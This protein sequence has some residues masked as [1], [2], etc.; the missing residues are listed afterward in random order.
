MFDVKQFSSDKILSH[1]DRINE[2][3]Q[4]GLSRPITYELDMTNVCNNNCP[5]CF[6]YHKRKENLHS[7]SVEKALDII[8]QIKEFGGK[9]VTFTGG[10][11][12]LCNPDTI[13]V[14]EY[15]YNRGF[16]KNVRKFLDTTL[17]LPIK[18]S[19]L[20]YQALYFPR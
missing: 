10:G 7:M 2:W 17:T 15:A 14:I 18:Q 9:A 19:L 8:D 6:G 12:P 4:I 1:I 5:F 13:K 11:E 3:L 20:R 16:Y